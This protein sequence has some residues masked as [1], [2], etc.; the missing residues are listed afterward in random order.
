M[1]IVGNTVGTTLP[2][3]NLKQ[4]NPNEGDFVK[5]KEIIP[6]AV[7]KA[8]E[9][10]KESGEFNGEPG[11]YTLK[12]GETIE[13]A[14]EWAQVIVDP[15][16]E[17]IKFYYTPSIT[18]TDTNTMTVS[19]VASAE[20]MSEVEDLTVVLPAGDKGDAGNPGVYTLATGETIDD[21]PDWAQVVVDP[22]AEPA[23]LEMVATFADGTTATYTIY[24]EVVAG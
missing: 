3:P 23:E 24:G 15:H 14:P 2:K 11:V 20:G 17:A 13:D 18:Q 1:K 21:A 16:S 10:A 19:F 9:Q 5:G 22:N 6:E 7:N 4:T 8:L 12:E